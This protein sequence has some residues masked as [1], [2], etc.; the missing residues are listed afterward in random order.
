MATWT[1]TDMYWSGRFVTATNWNN[2]FG[3][4]GNLA[5]LKET[6]GYFNAS[7]YNITFVPQNT[8]TNMRLTNNVT[9]FTIPADWESGAYA[10]RM[11]VF[12]AQ[13]QEAAVNSRRFCQ[14]RINGITS[15]LN[16]QYTFAA[17]GARKP[18]YHLSAH[19]VLQ[20]NDLIEY[21]FFQPNVA[22]SF[23]MSATIQKMG[24]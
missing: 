14:L 15:W 10:L 4:S 9:T 21:R 8:V 13:S 6:F 19:K 23:L 20:P 12:T 3:A 2:Y 24:L 18:I 7:F 22:G 5:Y 11:D 1:P 17:V 16:V